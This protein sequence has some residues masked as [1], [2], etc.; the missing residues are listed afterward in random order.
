MCSLKGAV[1]LTALDLGGPFPLIDIGS[2][3]IISACG[4]FFALQYN[5]WPSRQGDW[6]LVVHRQKVVHTS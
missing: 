5:H 6:I 4:F 1:K 3:F 2:E